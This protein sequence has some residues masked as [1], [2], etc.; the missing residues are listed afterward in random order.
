MLPRI[1]KARA[2]GDLSYLIQIGVRCYQPFMKLDEFVL[3]ESNTPITKEQ[4]INGHWYFGE[5]TQ[6]PAHYC[7]ETF[8]TLD[9]VPWGGELRFDTLELKNFKPLQHIPLGEITDPFE[10]E[11]EN[12]GFGKTMILKI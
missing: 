7:L 9:R 1:E 5:G 12:K 3:P 10:C 11:E 8:W 2:E 6:K 4:L